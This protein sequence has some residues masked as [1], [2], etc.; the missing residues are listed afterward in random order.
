[1]SG[2]T[3]R[4]VWGRRLPARAGAPC[5]ILATGAL[6]SALV[7][8]AD[9]GRVLTSRRALRRL[10]L[11]EV[12]PALDARDPAG[13]GEQVRPVQ[14][15]FLVAQRQPPLDGGEPVLHARGAF[16]HPPQQGQHQVV[17]GLAHAGRL[18]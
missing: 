13:Q 18:A 1:M 15:D 7:E 5:R 9:G 14:R 12:E 11:G 6:N 17:R 10:A 4:F 3:H 2:Q 16:V 8:F